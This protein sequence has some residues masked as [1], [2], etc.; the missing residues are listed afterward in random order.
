MPSTLASAAIFG[1]GACL[2][3]AAVCAGVKIRA[4]YRRGCGVH[5][6]DL[7]ADLTLARSYQIAFYLTMKSRPRVGPP[8]PDINVRA[9][10]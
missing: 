10:H 2:L 6:C 5:V 4:A 8:A 1:G 7:G 9:G 3:V